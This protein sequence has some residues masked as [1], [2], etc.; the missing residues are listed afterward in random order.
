MVPRTP[1]ASSSSLPCEG[2]SIDTR[3]AVDVAFKCPME[4]TLADSI[5]RR[6]SSINVARDEQIISTKENSQEEKGGLNA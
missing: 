2:I 1:L 6:V 4:Q 5:C 3:T